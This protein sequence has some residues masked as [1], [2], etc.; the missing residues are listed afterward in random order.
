MNKPAPI[1]KKLALIGDILSPKDSLTPTDQG[2]SRSD[3]D[4]TKMVLA[5]T[6]SHKPITERLMTVSQQRKSP[7]LQTVPKHQ[8]A[9]NPT[10]M[11]PPMAGASRASISSY[12][13]QQEAHPF[14]VTLALSSPMCILCPVGRNSSIFFG[15]RDVFTRIY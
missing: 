10:A 15:V 12:G 2:P 6:I 3:K 4:T 14:M 8:G 1:K 9:H 7:P 11:N 13:T 5:I